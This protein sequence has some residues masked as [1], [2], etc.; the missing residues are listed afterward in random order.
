MPKNY[1]VTV[2]T[3]PQD[4]PKEHE[5]SAS[6]LLAYHFKSDIIF[7]RSES[8]RT[9]DI[10]VGG[11]KWEIKSPTGGGKKTIENNLRSARKQSQ[12]IVLDLRRSKLHKARAIS[13]VKF[14]IATNAHNIKRLK[15]ITKSQK[16]IDIP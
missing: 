11:L 12:F 3:S 7:L 16:V 4:Y 1:K 14:Y 6:I 15:L 13:R 9:P 5:M 2:K 10:E 8:K